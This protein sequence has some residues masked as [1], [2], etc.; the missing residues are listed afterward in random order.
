MFRQMH[1]TCENC[2]RSQKRFSTFISEI[3]FIF[4]VVTND[5]NLTLFTALKKLICKCHRLQMFADKR[6]RKKKK[7]FNG[8]QS[9][10]FFVLR[11]IQ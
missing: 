11:K 7:L 2:F 5:R 3:D 4:S 10:Y 6:E 9:L 1:I 8:L